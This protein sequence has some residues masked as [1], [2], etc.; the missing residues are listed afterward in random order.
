MKSRLFSLVSFCLAAVLFMGCSDEPS[1]SVSSLSIT[2]KGDGSAVL[3]SG[4][5]IVWY[6]EATSELKL[7][8]APEEFTG[9]W[10]EISFMLDGENLF[11]AYGIVEDV[12][13]EL[14]TSLVVYR[15]SKGRY[16]LNDC[17]PMSEA[18]ASSPDVQAARE[19][20]AASWATFLCQLKAEKRLK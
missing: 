4:T 14:F 15:D 7:K 10:G 11:D 19:A 9:Y 6:N 1:T 13:S 12:R 18:V 20:R 17:Y 3:L 8:N 2:A 5:E 16:F